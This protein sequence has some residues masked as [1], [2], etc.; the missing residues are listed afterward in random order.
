[1]IK[2]ETFCVLGGDT[3]Q[4]FAAKSL[5]EDG[6]EVH[7]YGFDKYT[8][9]VFGQICDNLESAMTGADYILLPLPYSRD[10][11]LLNAPY[12][13]EAIELEQIYE[14]LMP[15]MMLFGGKISPEILHGRDIRAFDYYCRPQLQ[16]LN[17]V[18]TAEGAIQIAME[19][20]AVTIGGS[21]CLIVGCGR[22]GKILAQ[23][24]RGLN[25]EVTVTARKSEDL[26]WIEASGLSACH[27]GAI[28]DIIG[29]YDFV[30]NTVPARIIG[31]TE[32]DSVKDD[33]L[34][35]DLASAPG[36]IDMQYA[37][38]RGVQTIWSLSLPG[39]VAPATAGRII[40]QTVVD[41]IQESRS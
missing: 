1:M 10:G 21:Q 16:I 29:K 6:Y 4:L 36:G 22:I 3:R 23:L 24:L 8:E 41:I 5:L 39:K 33:C 11:A 18:P 31:R 20:S 30:F 12:C 15:W 13:S 7:V 40:K 34:L 25:A 27:T 2:Q 38:E 26:A 14:K 32:L 28:T 17:A 35:I 37:R 9:R 19:E